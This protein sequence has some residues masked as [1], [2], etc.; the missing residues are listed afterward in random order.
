MQILLELHDE[1]E[2][3]RIN[4]FTELVGINNRNLKDFTVDINQ[5]ISLAKLIP[6]NFVKVAES[7]ISDVETL[8]KLKINGFQGFL[9]GER[10][11]SSSRPELACKDFIS[12]L[13]KRPGFN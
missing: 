9:I 12:E 1:S 10:F 7:G 3:D 13:K 8:I 5:S 4:Q 6:D 11:M 2:M